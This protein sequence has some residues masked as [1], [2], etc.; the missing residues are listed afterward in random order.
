MITPT[1]NM[2]YGGKPMVVLNRLLEAREKWLHEGYKDA[3]VATAI[4]A[5]QSIRAATRKRKPTKRIVMG[6]RIA[7]TQ[8]HDVH[9]SHTRGGARCYR[10]GPRD[11]THKHSPRIELGEHCVQ[12][13]PPGAR[14]WRKCNIYHVKLT[15]EQADRWPK[16]PVEFDVVSE[17]QDGAMSYLERR[18]RNIAD[19][20]S[21]LA[22]QVLTLAMERLST[23]RPTKWEV[24]A[25]A[26]KS[27]NR[28][29]EISVN[30]SGED[31]RVAIRDN[32]SYAMDAVNGGRAGVTDALKRA[33]NRIA[34]MINHKAN[35]SL[36]EKLE[37]PFPEVKRR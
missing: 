7:V 1:L 20:E 16:Q 9:T 37:S 5:L 15:P 10:T 8:R 36:E 2:T 12:L 4:T 30:D 19:R 33:A 32:L 17:T 35:L 29:L 31:F 6:V 26:K 3:T 24:G 14:A 11:A 27:A 22:G 18:F 25:A 28:W 21:G 34:G 13:C 23:R